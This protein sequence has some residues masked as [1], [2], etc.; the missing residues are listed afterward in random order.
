MSRI[1]PPWPHYEA[2]E[3]AE[4]S[5]VLTSGKVNA[6]TGDKTKTFEKAFANYHECEYGLA[7]ANGTLALELALKTLELKAGDEI[8][9][10]CRTFIATAS[11]V[12]TCGGIPIVADVDG[13][14]QNITVDSIKQVYTPKCKGIIVVHLAGWPC[15][16]DPIMDFAREYNL[17]IIEDCAQAHGAKYKGKS[18]GS[19]GDFAAFSC[20]QD[21]IISTGGEG[22]VLITH[23]QEYW[24][25]AW[26][27]KDHGKNYDRVFSAEHPPGFRWYCDSFGSNYRLT[28]LQSAIGLIQL[29][30]L[31]GW[32]EKR[33]AYAAIFNQRFSAIPGLNVTVPEADYLHA[34]YKYYV[35][36]DQATLA[37]GWDRDR[38]MM[39]LN[40]NGLPCAVGICPEIQ[41]ET[42]FKHYPQ[43]GTFESAK[44]L[45]NITLMFPVHPTLSADDI[46]YMADSVE[47]IMKQ[48]VKSEVHCV[49]H[50]GRIVQDS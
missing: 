29:S 47:E 7:T 43:K 13:V 50:R 6:W 38:I 45:G 23:R 32:L 33:R 20:C 27:F 36:V 46:Y 1:F 14:S 42:A 26:S 25:K 3:I 15:D 9:V 11:A 28:E 37:S 48:A 40:E 49:Q 34:Y 35:Q 21:K 31:E 12:V 41:L 16:M 19:F 24:K 30:K 8:I 2:D 22:G 10:P 17:F 5:H 18:V 44:Q 39:T 4:V